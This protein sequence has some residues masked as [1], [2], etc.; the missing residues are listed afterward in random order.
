MTLL[1]IFA[2][3]A[4]VLSAIGLYG[5]ISYVVAERT[6]EI[7]IRIALGA[8]PRDIAGAVVVRGIVLSALGLTIGLVAAFW[9]TRVIRSVLHGVSTTDPLSFLTAATLLLGVSLLA[10]AIPMRRAMR[11]DPVIA[12][13]GD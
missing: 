12:M 3:L 1:A 11:V 10:C 4:V 8:T 5:V 6:R 2:G 13:R 9:G 7:G